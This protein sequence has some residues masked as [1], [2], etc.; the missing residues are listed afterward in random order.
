[1]KWLMRQWPAIRSTRARSWMTHFIGV[2]RPAD[3][4]L[5]RPLRLLAV[6]Q[7]ERGFQS[8]G[9]LDRI[10]VGPEVHVEEA[11]SVLQPMVVERRDV[12]AMLPQGQGDGIHFLVDEDEVPGDRGLPIRRRLE[13]NY[14]RHRRGGQIRPP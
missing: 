10:V 12:D 8:L 7:L 4:A 2:L 13:V 11:R 3:R 5:F 9:E 1:M 6:G 14:W